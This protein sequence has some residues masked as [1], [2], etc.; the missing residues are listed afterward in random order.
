MNRFFYSTVLLFLLSCNSQNKNEASHD[1]CYN[2][3]ASLANYYYHVGKIDSS[4]LFLQNAL[5]HNELIPQDYL[6]ALKIYLSKKMRNKATPLLRLM[7]HYGYKYKSLNNEEEVQDFFKQNADIANSLKSQSKI[8]KEFFKK[9][10]ISIIV[11]S[12]FNVDQENRKVNFGKDMKTFESV[13][14]GIRKELVRTIQSYG[15]PRIQEIGFRTHGKLFTLLLHNFYSSEDT[16]DINNLIK[17]SFK[18]RK[19]SCLEYGMMMDR[20][21]LLETGYAK[22][23][24]A[25]EFDENFNYTFG[26]NVKEIDKIDSL[27][28]FSLG[29][30]SLKNQAE[31]GNAQIPN[32]YKPQQ[33][34]CNLEHREMY[35]P[36]DTISLPIH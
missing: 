27:R 9:L 12:L 2:N 25:G 11:D 6:T 30:T 14:A 10:P 35:S 16:F 18:D 24:I 4:H 21:S 32:N 15:V 28:Y 34:I 26:F 31:I 22:Y 36:S 13:E 8:R 3:N 20:K 5:G 7:T 17:E 33:Y 23:A 1:I 19:Y 29:L